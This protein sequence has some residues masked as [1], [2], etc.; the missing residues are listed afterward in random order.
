MEHV[1]SQDGTSIAYERSGM[2][3]PLLLVHGTGIDHTQWAPLIPELAQ[4]FTVYAVDR[5]GR[6]QSGDTASYAIER[7]FEDISV[8]I[9]S[10]D[11]SVNVL[12]HSYGAL[13]SLEAALRTSHVCRLLLYEPPIYTTVKLSYPSEIMRNIEALLKA[14]EEEKLLLMLYELAQTPKADVALLRSLPSWKA[15]LNAVHTIPREQ[16]SAKNYTFNAARFRKLE[17][18]TLLMAG[19]ETHPFYKAAVE[20]LHDALPNSRM[21]VLPNQGHEAMDT[22]SQVFLREAENFF[23]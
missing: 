1:I 13:C 9:D 16:I 14:G 6:G 22:A 23:R 19:S 12:G 17:T 18:P 4:H 15:R 20:A 7:E 2:G 21:V 5:R 10:I 8:L 11:G 3:P